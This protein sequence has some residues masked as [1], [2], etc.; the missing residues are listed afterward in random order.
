MVK[1]YIA[2]GLT[3][4]AGAVV[5]NCVDK[6]PER[7]WCV[8]AYAKTLFLVGRLDLAESVLQKG[9]KSSKVQS[10]RS[11]MTI[12]LSRV[13]AKSVSIK[14]ALDLLLNAEK[15]DPA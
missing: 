4:K 8:V 9:M 2:Q 14:D 5:K 15:M 13:R 6:T 11:E 7:I 10:E 1:S 3:D 12:L